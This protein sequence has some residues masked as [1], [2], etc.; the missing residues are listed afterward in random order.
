MLALFT[1]LLSVL[2]YLL[3]IGM[4]TAALFFLGWRV[5]KLHLRCW[6]LLLKGDAQKARKASFYAVAPGVIIHELSHYLMALLMG[7][8]VVRFS[9]FSPTYDAETGHWRLGSVEHTAAPD[10]WR[11][12]L[13][14]AAPLVSGPLVLLLILLLLGV[15]LPSGTEPV[16][17]FHAFVK[18]FTSA[19][20][21]SPI[22]LY[23]FMN[24]GTTVLVS[25]QDMAQLK[26]ALIFGIPL[27]VLLLFISTVLPTPVRE[28]AGAYAGQLAAGIIF[29]LGAMIVADLLAFLGLQ[30]LFRA[31]LWNAHR[32]HANSAVVR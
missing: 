11:N 13:I 24:L 22:L 29:L 15:A 23:A 12:L 27:T 18:A 28:G 32:K 21:A 1:T 14:G 20:W 10:P 3:V 6:A 9:L 7:E 31:L 19:G 5:Q 25:P 2:S 30:L 4:A 17:L 8:K 26:P 16:L